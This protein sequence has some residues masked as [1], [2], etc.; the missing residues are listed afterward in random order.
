[1]LIFIATSRFLQTNYRTKTKFI[2]RLICIDKSI[3][4]YLSVKGWRSRSGNLLYRANKVVAQ[5]TKCFITKK[6][7]VISFTHKFLLNYLRL[8][9]GFSSL[10]FWRV[11]YSLIWT[12]VTVYHY[13]MWPW[14]TQKESQWKQRHPDYIGIPIK[15]NKLNLY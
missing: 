10:V 12:E 9:S 14:D 11:R 8:R 1:M 2:I 13:I 6:H 7:S 3:Q 5:E 15:F 4:S